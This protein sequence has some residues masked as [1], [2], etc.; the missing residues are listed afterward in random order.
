[1][2]TPGGGGTTGGSFTG[3][4]AGTS[5]GAVGNGPNGGN[6]QNGGGGG[7]DRNSGDEGKTIVTHGGCALARPNASSPF[8]LLLVALAALL[9]FDRRRSS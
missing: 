2:C 8:A 4:T 3:G 7:T 9:R 5:T 6:G 1:V